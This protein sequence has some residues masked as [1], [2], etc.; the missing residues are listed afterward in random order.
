MKPFLTAAAIGALAAS[1][2]AAAPAS[3]FPIENGITAV[4]VAHVLQAKGYKADIGVDDDGDPR[5]KSAADGTPFTVFFYGCN[6]GPRCTSLTFQAG[7]HIDGGLTTAKINDW[8]HEK[9]FIKGWLDNTND[10]YGEMD[11]DTEAGFTTEALG[12][13]LDLWVAQ[14]PAFKQYIGF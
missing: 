2:L 11:V 10:P 12:N 8:N 4:Q 5:V 3:A 6:G 13:Y 14:L 9:R 7:F 1:A